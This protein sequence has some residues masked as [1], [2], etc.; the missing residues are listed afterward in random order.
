MWKKFGFYIKKNIALLVKVFTDH[1]SNIFTVLFGRAEDQTG[2][3]RND[4]GHQGNN[5]IGI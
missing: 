1:L 5:V 2:I 4:F 3:I